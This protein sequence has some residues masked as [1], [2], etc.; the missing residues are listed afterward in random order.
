MLLI[1]FLAKFPVLTSGKKLWVKLITKIH[2]SP[3]KDFFEYQKIM[4]SNILEKKK[5]KKENFCVGRFK[6]IL[7]SYV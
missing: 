4:R 3:T 5:M 1:T 6:I 7:F 2:N